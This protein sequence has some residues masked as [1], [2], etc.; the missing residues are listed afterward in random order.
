MIAL[1]YIIQLRP[2]VPMSIEKPCKPAS[3]S[4]IMRWLNGGMIEI[5]GEKIN[6]KDKVNYPIKSLVFSLNQKPEGAH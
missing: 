5:N 4:E 1:D 6:A 2:A 3:N